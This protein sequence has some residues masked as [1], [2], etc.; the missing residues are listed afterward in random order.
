MSFR[1][2]YNAPLPTLWLGSVVTELSDE[3]CQHLICMRPR[4]DC[5]R[6][7]GGQEIAFFFL[8]LVELEKQV[9]PRKGN[10]QIVA[11][12]DDGFERLGIEFDSS[13]WVHRKFRTS[14]GNDAI[15][16]ANSESDGDFKFTDN[17]NI[18]YKWRGELKAE[19][20]QRIAQKFAESLSRVAIDESEWLRRMAK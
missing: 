8:P 17:H 4:C 14:T 10:E 11:R 15:F 19:Y 5:V 1:T 16:A 6:L 9:K 3:G 18:E 2:V 7:D 13:S 20:A 12:L